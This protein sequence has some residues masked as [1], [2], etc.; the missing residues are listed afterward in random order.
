MLLTGNFSLTIFLK[1]KK[2]VRTYQ[3][4]SPTE[5]LNFKKIHVFHT[6]KDFLPQTFLLLDSS[7]NSSV[8]SQ[9]VKCINNQEGKTTE[10]WA[11]ENGSTRNTA[12]GTTPSLPT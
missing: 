8:N 7:Q 1:A 4:T 11:K 10:Y 3:K 2:E 5:T 12:R 6:K 9:K